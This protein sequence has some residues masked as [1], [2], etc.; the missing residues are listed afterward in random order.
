MGKVIVIVSGKGGVGKT[1]FAANLGGILSQKG[2]KVVLVDMDMGLRNLDICIGL[3]NKVVY[4]IADVIN[5]VC[6]IKQALIRDRRFPELYLIGAPQNLEKVEITP[7]HTKII[8][9]KLAE[10]FDYVIID[11]PA[12]IDEGL[13]NSI[14][15]ADLGIIV[16]TPEYAALRDADKVDKI[17]LEN[18]LTNRKV[19]INKLKGDLINNGAMPSITE[20]S[21]MLRADI[22]GYIQEDDNI[23]IATNNGTP[24][25]LKT[26]TYIHDNFMKIAERIE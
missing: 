4:D 17:L 22:I 23:Q 20:V 12:G 15:G 25:V 1:M 11:G 21:K 19:V 16:T 2:S 9:E 3:E 26:G 24:I 18:G 14:S 6:R 7:L 10:T 8:Y 5:G 13:I